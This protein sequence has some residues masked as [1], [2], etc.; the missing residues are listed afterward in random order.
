MDRRRFVAGGAAGAAVA[1]V[2]APAV[3]QTQPRI[4]WRCPGSFP[5]SLDTLYGTQEHICRRVGEITEGAFQIQP[6]AP[7]EIVPALQVLDAAGT[8]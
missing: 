1:A 7:G 3:A 8:G 4:R 5:K 2:A 6:F